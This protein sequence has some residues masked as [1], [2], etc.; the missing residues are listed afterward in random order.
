MAACPPKE[1]MSWD[2]KVIPTEGAFVSNPGHAQSRSQIQDADAK[3]SHRKET[4]HRARLFLAWLS[5][6]RTTFDKFPARCQGVN[7]TKIS[8]VPTYDWFVWLGAFNTTRHP[9]KQGRRKRVECLDCR[10]RAQNRRIQLAI[11][12]HFQHVWALLQTVGI[13]GSVHCSTSASS[14]MN[15]SIWSVYWENPVPSM[16]HKGLIRKTLRKVFGKWYEKRS[17]LNTFSKTWLIKKTDCCVAKAVYVRWSLV[18][19]GLFI[20]KNQKSR[21][22]DCAC[23]AH[24]C[25]S[26]KYKRTLRAS[27]HQRWPRNSLKMGVWLWR[28][29]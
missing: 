9:P 11:L 20:V 18:G 23:Q 13:G 24:K 4:V 7:H 27:P 1:W 21:L 22:R 19:I 8:W 26:C 10:H 2:V 12:Q 17:L 14:K 25:W 16:R 29:R 5:C 3:H 15:Q 6:F 28:D